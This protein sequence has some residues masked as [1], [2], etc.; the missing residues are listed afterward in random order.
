MSAEIITSVEPAIADPIIPIAVEKLPAVE[1]TPEEL[2]A[3][4]IQAVRE[5]GDALDA[6]QALR[7]WRIGKVGLIG[8]SIM[9]LLTEAGQPLGAATVAGITGT[10]FAAAWAGLRTDV[11]CEKAFN[12]TGRK[13]QGA[14]NLTYDVYRSGK[15]SNHEI[16]VHWRGIAH[17][18]K[19]APDAAERLEKMATLARDNNIAQL[20]IDKDFANNYLPDVEQ[21][22]TTTTA[23]Q[24][25]DRAKNLPVGGSTKQQQ[26]QVASPEDWLDALQKMRS[27]HGMHTVSTLV[28]LLAKQDQD[29]PLV[30]LHAEYSKNPQFRRT[31]LLRQLKD[32]FKRELSEPTTEIIGRPETIV[33]V[34]VQKEA[35]IDGM[36]VA[37]C[38][39]GRYDAS[40]KTPLETALGLQPGQLEQLLQSPTNEMKTVRVLEL[41]M[42]K[43]LLEQSERL[44]RNEEGHQQ[45][46]LLARFRYPTVPDVLGLD[47]PTDDTVKYSRLELRVR[48]TI[49]FLI[50][51]AI[52]SVVASGSALIDKSYTD[53]W[54][55][56]RQQLATEQG[57]DPKNADISNDQI[58]N[59]LNN[60]S[61]ANRIWGDWR[62]VRANISTLWGVFPADGKGKTASQ[63]NSV[64]W[65]DKSNVGNVENRP[66]SVEWTLTPHNM[67]TAGYWSNATSHVLNGEPSDHDMKPPEAPSVNWTI[68]YSS[69]KGG[70]AM[71]LP[72][73]YQ[74][75]NGRSWIKVE[76]TLQP[77][78]TINNA[79]IVNLTPIPVLNNSKPVAINL[80][81]K[82]LRLKKDTNG[83]YMVMSSSS[84]QALSGKLEYWLEPDPGAG[85]RATTNV[86]LSGKMNFDPALIDEVMFKAIPGLRL[87]S[88]DQQRAAVTNYLRSNLQYSKQ[89]FGNDFARQDI[90][91]WGNWVER[92]LKTGKADCTVADTE[93][94]LYDTTLNPAIGFNNA[95]GKGQNVLSSGELHQW[96]VDKNGTTWDATPSLPPAGKETSPDND[97]PAP[98]EPWGVGA[99][100]VV[101]GLTVLVQRRKI[102]AGV[103]HGANAIAGGLAGHNDRKL[104]KTDLN[105][106]RIAAIAAEEALYSPAVNPTS[107]RNRAA[108]SELTDQ[109]VRAKLNRPDIHSKA[110]ERALRRQRDLPNIARILRLA[111]RSQ[112]TVRTQNQR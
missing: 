50:A 40:G 82:A 14:L 31:V 68:S 22:G 11:E 105:S 110:A 61:A 49:S 98:L 87:M 84:K 16:T 111:R 25:L 13:A 112:R 28:G 93:L 72:T 47:Q 51:A 90:R 24:W 23:Y 30:R 76:R 57:L 21:P 39:N 94:N 86:G 38:V 63:G 89:P 6:R 103:G 27:E 3:A 73:K 32:G 85:P 36:D 102:A 46:P 108:R 66:E 10:A 9:G 35:V 78:D 80:N 95:P 37:Y 18:E 8:A 54:D 33:R 97:Q 70:E 20:A 44:A 109:Q 77:G 74:D 60:W 19:E 83:I 2:F 69:N 56:A 62:G 58:Q 71:E 107:I 100:I 43:L 52:G 48:K 34:K 15:R 75:S 5:Q 79:N 42:Y 88:V 7:P 45:S 64:L 104:Q 81:G 53:V 4:Q 65:W 67:D 96:S 12:V 106:L 26:W 41:S 101:G 1:Q 29:H 92:S 91:S 55:K 59:R 99:A 17:D